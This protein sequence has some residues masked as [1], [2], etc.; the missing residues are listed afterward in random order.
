LQPKDF[1]H[2][3]VHSQYS[4]LHGAIFIDRLIDQ[5][6]KFGM[7]SVAITDH[8]NL[9]GAVEFYE[10]AK[11]EGIHPILGCEVYYLVKGSR[12]DKTHKPKDDQLAHLL[13]LVQNQ[14]GY[15]N[16][17]RL[18]SSSYV[19]GFYYKPRLD[20]EILKEHSQGLIAL[21]CCSRG[22]VPRR[23]IEG[24]TGEALKAALELAQIFQDR[25]YLELGEHGLAHE[26]L[27]NDFLVQISREH[28]IPLVVTNN[29]HYLHRKDREAHE[30]LLCIQAG[31]LLK[32][33]DRLSYEG[34]EFYFKSPEE[35]CEEFRDFPEALENTKK[36][37]E[38]C[39]FDF[40][41]KTYYFPKFV[42]DSQKTLEEYLSEKVYEGFEE[43][44]VQIQKFLG[45]KAEAEKPR[46]Q[47]RIEMELKTILSM[48]FASY[49]LI[50]ADFINYAKSK[51]IPV[52]PGRG[53]AAGSLVAYCL[54]IT[55]LDPLPYHLLFER[56]L[57]PERISMPDM[58]IDF[59]MNRRDEVIDY[60]ARKFG[61]VSQIITFG[62]MKAKAVIRD[63]G[64]VLDMPYSEVDRIAK[65]IPNALNMT[66]AEALK[67]EP[68][69]Q[70]LEKTQPNVQK[71][72]SIARSLEGLN[73]HASTHAA[74]VVISDR[75]LTEFMPLYR[76]P[77]EEIVTQFDMK[78][79]EKIGLVK[80]D[81]LGLKTLTVIENTLKI[82]RRTRGI[83]VNLNELSLDDPKVYKTFS[84]GD[85]MG[86]F[87]L[88]SSGMRDLL[89]KMKPNTF[90]DLIALVALYRPGPLGSGMVDDFI[91]RKH[92][93]KIS[94][95]IPALEPI[96]K[97]TYGVIVYQ[98][99]VMQIASALGGFSL[100][101]ADLLRRA[102]GKKKPEEMAQQKKRFLEGS[103]QKSIPAK[104]A[105]KIF[106]LMAK[107]AE[108]G[109]NKS[110]SAAYAL[111]SYQTAYLKTHFMVEYMAS[112]LT[113]EM[114]DTD[115]IL[116]YINDLQSHGIQVLPP[117]INESYRYFSV[118]SEKEMRFGLAAVKNVGEAAIES[119]I[120]VRKK[121]G[122]FD[123]FFHFCETIDQRRV[124]RKVIESLI[125]CGA[126]DN[127]KI[128]RSQALQALDSAIAHG[129]T[130]QRDQERGQNTL[131]DPLEDKAVAPSLP[132]IE[133]WS[134]SQ[135]LKYERE[136]LGFYITGHPLKAFEERIKKITSVD[137]L[138]IRS[139]V[140]KSEVTLAGMVGSL[141]EINTK[142]GDRMAFVTLEDLKGYLEVIV[143]ADLYK[144]VQ[145][146]LHLD[147]PLLIR[148]QVDFNE[149]QVKLLATQIAL[150]KKEDSTPQNLHVRVLAEAL[151]EN[152]LKTFR[153]ILSRYPGGSP[154]YLHLVSREQ[155]ETVLKL[156]REL[157]AQWNSELEQELTTLLGTHS[158][159]RYG[160][161]SMGSS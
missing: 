45:D 118:Q 65:L 112:L 97:D 141:K 64:R 100:G 142:K 46:Y 11:K 21:S 107:F 121:I 159:I 73:R 24:K 18:I 38:K 39:R 23:I 40:D 42:P 4:L 158:Q 1:V 160:A 84:L 72:L 71:L 81:F 34:E 43:R 138:S 69:L 48:G 50:V 29:A 22:E 5:V 133:E 125:K 161:L 77:H 25:F 106:D 36:I 63:V 116:V 6:K 33:E 134:D 117:D 82:I 98:E 145:H 3:H 109:F 67:T 86:I 85:G 153:L 61:N 32:E 78:A 131:F 44:W 103:T 60:V 139:T 137:T 143:F 148:G 135:K 74:G 59:C 54:K 140:D 114:G 130:K 147:E 51:E 151:N 7:T 8:V 154:V 16:L 87:Q 14:E 129:T 101:E 124:N 149:D 99:Q 12:L 57:N 17:C 95:E 96:L 120:E 90:E 55:D 10:K 49:F 30:A 156:P 89:V 155:K 75:S 31:K 104:K 88:E 83:L 157:D 91:G 136:T 128:L 123:S 13:L 37:A 19:E 35:M 62:K 2:L 126:F 144:N 108:Y 79:V 111:I 122:R 105:E 15:K 26:K 92:G 127:L 66:L 113:H 110:H 115:K 146:L 94:Y 93:K 76:G 41:F 70:E 58:D 47:K 28:Q 20:K 80:F 132:A 9:F 152:K 102:M 27:V 150:L 53:S 52:G 68:R 119:I 56:F